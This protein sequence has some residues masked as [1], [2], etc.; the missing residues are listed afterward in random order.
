MVDRSVSGEAARE[1]ERVELVR[2]EIEEAR[3]PVA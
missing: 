2:A 3:R 1:L